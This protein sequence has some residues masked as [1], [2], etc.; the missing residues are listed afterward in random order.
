MLLMGR[1]LLS[2][3]QQGTQNGYAYRQEMEMRLAAESMVEKQWLRIKMDAGP[4]QELQEDRM[5]QLDSGIYEGLYYTVYARC[6]GGHIY[7]I[8]TAFRRETALD[9]IVEPH[10]MVKG[11]LGKE[12]NHYVWL[13]WAP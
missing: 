10:F 7:L 1:G 13:G 9:W 11:V 3:A 6:W 4:L 5:I 8:A 12:E 2:F